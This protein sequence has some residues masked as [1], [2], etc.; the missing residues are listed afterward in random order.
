MPDRRLIYRV[1]A[2]QRMFEREISDADV[3]RA[4]HV[5]VADN[6]AD[7]ERDEMCDL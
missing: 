5:V 2:I 4:L 3:K 7:G 1:H 6:E